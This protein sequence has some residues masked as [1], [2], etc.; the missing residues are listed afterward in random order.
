[1]LCDDLIFY[2]RVSGAAR[3]KGLNVRQVKSSDDLLSG[4]RRDQPRGV[5][6]D[7][8]NPGLNLPKILLELGVICP[9]MP[10]LVAYG[11][12]VEAEVLSNARKAG[13]NRV[14]PRSQF[15]KELESDLLIWM[16]SEEDQKPRP[17]Q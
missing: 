11:S 14:L 16:R 4:M 5:I 15:V 10:Y 3:A 7:L 1:M 9:K 2:S 6:I 13:C 17:T 8:Q 12:H